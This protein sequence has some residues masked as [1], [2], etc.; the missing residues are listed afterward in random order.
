MITGAYQRFAYRFFRW[1]DK[2]PRESLVELL[3]KADLQM[4]P[5]MFVGT[6]ALTCI[7]ATAASLVGSYV[8][9]TYF[10]QTSLQLVLTI[11]ITGSAAAISLIA[12]PIVTTNKIGSKN[13]KINSALPFVLAYMATLSSAGMNPVE[14]LRHVALKDFGPV[15]T[16]FRKIVYRFDVLGEDVITAINFIALNTPSENL[17]DILIGISNIIVSG[18]SLKSYC[19]QESKNLFDERKAKLKQFI[20]GLAAYSEGY[21]GGVIVAV[22]MGVIGIIIIGS[23]GVKVLP[24][25][26]T[27]DVML[28]FTFFVVPFVNVIFLGFLELKFSGDST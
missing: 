2:K 8:V 25:L 26:N 14:V 12:F 13:V 22:I 10:Y 4:L 20:D 18:G 6:I 23:L 17:H 9:F 24:Y 15:S 1:V 5:G 21:V 3:Y 27:Q 11:A 19:E 28:I 16:E 7:I